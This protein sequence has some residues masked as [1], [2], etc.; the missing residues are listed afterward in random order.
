MVISGKKEFEASHSG[1]DGC[2]GQIFGLGGGA[3]FDG[4]LGFANAATIKM[5]KMRSV[6]FMTIGR[7]N[8]PSV[9]KLSAV[10]LTDF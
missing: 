9:L 4:D 5:H 2:A 3:G 7:K 8:K 1:K 10:R 6:L